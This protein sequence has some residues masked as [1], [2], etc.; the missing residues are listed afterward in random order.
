M[1]IKVL[2]N[3]KNSWLITC[4]LAAQHKDDVSISIY[5]GAANNPQVERCSETYGSLIRRYL[6]ALDI[7]ESIFAEACQAL[8][9]MATE[10]AN[11][12]LSGP[13]SSFHLPLSHQLDQLKYPE[14]LSCI[15]SRVVEKSALPHPD[16]FHFNTVLANQGRAPYSLQSFPFDAEYGFYLNENRLLEFIKDHAMR[17][18]SDVITIIEDSIDDDLLLSA[19]L[20][21][22]T[23]T[24]EAFDST[25]FSNTHLSPCNKAIEAVIERSD[26]PYSP[27]QYRAFNNGWMYHICGVNKATVGIVFDEGLTYDEAENLVRQYIDELYT[28]NKPWAI[29]S[30]AEKTC[31]AHIRRQAWHEN[32]VYLGAAMGNLEQ[33][34]SFN[35]EVLL[36]SL[37][38]LSGLITQNAK[39]DVAAKHFNQHVAETVNSVI[40]FQ[41][42]MFGFAQRPGKSFSLDLRSRVAPT[43]TLARL[44]QQWQKSHHVPFDTVASKSLISAQ[45]WTTLLCGLNAFAS[46]EH[47]DIGNTQIQSLQLFYNACARNFP[48]LENSNKRLQ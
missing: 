31:S 10:Y 45:Q 20:T 4:F 3:D 19:D 6:F 44:L 24:S 43:P 23:R 5:T 34:G 37:F 8:P 35:H 18:Y 14:F 38:A 32:I 21:I 36:S 9:H 46:N 39:H 48:L 29:S 16:I 27:M 40:D 22:E 28:D 13:Y 17:H 1:H 7:D 42:A 30:I 2:G 15:K 11:W 41:L 26:T 12:N 33:L 47:T 25:L